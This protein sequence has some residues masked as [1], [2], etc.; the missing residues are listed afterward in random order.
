MIKLLRQGVI[1]ATVLVALSGCTTRNALIE[2][3]DWYQ[4]GF[5]DGKWGQ[6]A[7][8]E[9]SLTQRAEQVADADTPDYSRYQEGYQVGINQYC[10]YEQLEQFGLE[11]KMDWGACEFRREEGGLYTSFWQQGFDRWMNF[12]GPK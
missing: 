8:S 11:G 7:L 2:A 4:I 6:M 1:A 10:S 3:G 5:N 12:E 9:A